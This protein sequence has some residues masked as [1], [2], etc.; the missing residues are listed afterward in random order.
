MSPSL[1]QVYRSSREDQLDGVK[2]SRRDDHRTVIAEDN[3]FRALRIYAQGTIDYQSIVWKPG[4]RNTEQ[5]SDRDICLRGAVEKRHPFSQRGSL[6]WQETLNLAV[7]QGATNICEL[8]SLLFILEAKKQWNLG[9]FCESIGMASGSSYFRCYQEWQRALGSGASVIS[10]LSFV[11]SMQLLWQAMD[12]EK[13]RVVSCSLQHM[14]PCCLGLHFKRL[15][16]FSTDLS[17]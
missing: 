12:L 7:G 3:S 16:P 4:R 14:V 15:W 1:L 13:T 10:Y 2:Q 17:N 9:W 6:Q 5:A 11:L 8:F